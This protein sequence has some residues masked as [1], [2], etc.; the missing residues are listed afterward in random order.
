MRIRKTAALL[1]ATAI[2]ITITIALTQTAQAAQTEPAPDES[3]PSFVQRTLSAPI[4]F[5]EAI[6]LN[7]TGRFDAVALHYDNFSVAG[8]YSLNSGVPVSEFLD[9]FSRNYS[10]SPRVTAIVVES[11]I[12]K[13]DAR[14]YTKREVAQRDTEA[15]PI[16]VST[17][18]YSPPPV[19]FAG[20]VAQSTTEFLERGSTAAKT[21]NRSTSLAASDEWRP[22]HTDHILKTVGGRASLQSGYQWQNNELQNFPYAWGMEFEINLI[23][24]SVFAPGNGRPACLD[25]SYKDRF[26]AS[27]YSYNWSVTNAYEGQVP[28]G[29]YADYNDLSDS[30]GTNSIAIGSR[31]PKGT[32]G[33][34]GYYAIL[35]NIS[36]PRGLTA[37]SVASANLQAVSEVGCNLYPAALT[38]CMGTATGTWPNSKPQSRGSL[39]SSRGWV[40]PNLCW[41]AN[42]YGLAGTPPVQFSCS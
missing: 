20:D 42:G 6:R 12:P 32:G 15:L 38:D 27:N 28:S 29:L 36:A 37:S 4:S 24:N 10:T 2:C 8:E 40:A 13:K 18:P 30:C 1:S 33:I 35:V 41:Q 16:D 26:W 5:E 11:D 34:E 25:A 19:H 14:T 39:A 22:F 21:Q 3:I 23:N 9:E 17:A 7:E 31:Y